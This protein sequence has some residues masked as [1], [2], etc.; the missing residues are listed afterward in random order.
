MHEY[1]IYRKMNLIVA[2]FTKNDTSEF[3]QEN[4]QLMY[5]IF[6]RAIM[7]LKI[8]NPIKL[9]SNWTK[10]STKIYTKFKSILD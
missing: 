9:E 10:E 1:V 2:R 8:V 6:I 5:Y 4:G 3:V 7:K